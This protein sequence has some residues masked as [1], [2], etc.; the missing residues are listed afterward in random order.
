[1]K[2]VVRWNAILLLVLAFAVIQES[3]Y[4]CSPTLLRVY[5]HLNYSVLCS[6]WLV[7]KMALKNSIGTE[8]PWQQF[9]RH[10]TQLAG[11][12]LFAINNFPT[13]VLLHLFVPI[14]LL[15]KRSK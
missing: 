5:L 14:A 11:Y 7:P 1:M 13:A 8:T 15:P 12:Q 4:L 9:A 6:C 2:C 3:N 10:P